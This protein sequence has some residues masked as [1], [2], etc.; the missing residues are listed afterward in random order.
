MRIVLIVRLK[1]NYSY[2]QCNREKKTLIL[3]NVK[4]NNNKESKG[5]YDANSRCELT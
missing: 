4:K 1:V 2:D 3:F 5:S